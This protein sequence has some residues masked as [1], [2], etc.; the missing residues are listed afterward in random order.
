MDGTGIQTTTQRR[1]RLPGEEGVWMFVLGDL[2]VFALFFGTYLF[3]RAEAPT[4]YTDSQRSLDA[5]LGLANTLALLTS[6]A[7]LAI[8]V[9]SAREGAVSA[10]RPWIL[11]AIVFG[12]GFALGKTIEYSQKF[13]AGYGVETN[14]FFMFFFMLTGIHFVHVL[15][16]LVLLSL[17][18]RTMRAP[19]SES[20]V[21]LLES[22]AIYWHMVDL[23]WIVLFT[24]FYLLR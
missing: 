19:M 7:A 16:G 6:S 1:E 10:A 13:S 2:L 15:V 18:Y 3:Y 21:R 20:G 9:K 5:G 17:L 14:E 8:G 24:L 4:L 23:L 12:V 22:G 11:A